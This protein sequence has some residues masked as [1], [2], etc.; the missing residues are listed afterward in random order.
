[1]MNAT[2]IKG[3]ELRQ[4]QLIELDLLKEFDRV[5]RKHGIKYTLDGGTLIGAVRHKGFIPW[6]DDVDVSMLREEYEKFK[7]VTGDLDPKICWFQDHDTDPDYRWGYGKLRR[8]GTQLVREG[9]E[10]MPGRTGVFLDIFPFDDVPQSL[11]GQIWQDFHCFCLRKILW[12]E[13]G[14]VTEEKTVWRLWFKLLAKIPV[15]FVFRQLRTYARRSLKGRSNRARILMYPAYGKLGGC[16]WPLQDRYS[17]PKRWLTEVV[18]FDFEGVSLLGSKESDGL[19]RRQYG[20]YMT[21]PAEN[22]RHGVL[23]AV[24]HDFGGLHLEGR[25]EE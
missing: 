15:V 14:K 23:S 12:A 19:L 4:L 2:E 7:R 9:Q 16:R 5:C 13:V 20:D 24:L 25:M 21:L 8:T 18:N 3:A 1:M 6:D 17:V 10:H 22:E 11:V